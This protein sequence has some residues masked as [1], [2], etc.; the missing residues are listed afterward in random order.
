MTPSL[1]FVVAVFAAPAAD[2]PT[3]LWQ[4]APE[5]KGVFA[6]NP[7][8]SKDRAVLIIPGLKIH[9]FRPVYATRPEIREYQ[10][11]SSELVKA[12]A[13]D[14]DVFSFGYAQTV[15][16]DAVAHSPGLRAA[17]AQIKAAGYR[18]IVLIGHSAGGVISRIFAE[19]YPESGVTKVISVAA[20][21][22]GSEIA[23]LRLGYPRVQAPFVESLTPEVRA[24]MPQR[25]NP[26]DKLQIACVVCKVKRIEADGLVKLASQ[27]PEECRKAGVPAV[28]VQTDHWHAMLSPAS[29][30][31]ISELAKEK[32]TRWSPEAVEKAHKVLFGEP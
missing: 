7:P 6:V 17:V 9:P 18:E 32:L 20:P 1:S 5:R 27:W 15:P 30:K 10:Q 16:L 31:V 23:S 26:D 8:R 25:K 3:E 4:V 22:G 19:A 14:S 24:D 11:T 12:L 21:H 29:I 13:K 28:L 2:L